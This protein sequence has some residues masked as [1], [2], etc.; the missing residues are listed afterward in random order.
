[1]K[2]TAR[3][4]DSRYVFT[5]AWCTQR[6]SV[7]ILCTTGQSHR[8]AATTI[9]T[10]PGSV[11][12]EI[13]T[14]IEWT[15][16]LSWRKLVHVC[17]S[18]RHISPLGLGLN[19][20]LLCTHETPFRKNLGFW[21]PIPLIIDYNTN[22]GGD[23]GENLTRS[24]EDD[25]IASLENPHHEHY[26]EI[27]VTSSPLATAMYEP[28]PMLT[29]LW[30]SSE[31]V[32]VPPVLPEAFLRGSAPRLRFA[33]LEGIPFPASFCRLQTLG[34]SNSRIYTQEWLRFTGRD[35]CRSGRVDTLSIGF[36]SLTEDSCL[37]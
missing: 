21:P 17:Q 1:V 10:V 33:H 18:W 14:S 9:S 26:V 7:D 3:D 2:I 15:T 4:T 35:G 23:E 20:Q 11:L 37:P 24:D 32:N 5:F 8:H 13:L 34:I 6:A 16:I 19:P 22:W 36:L 28:F 12:L 27:F 25:V 29:H 30:L 31:D